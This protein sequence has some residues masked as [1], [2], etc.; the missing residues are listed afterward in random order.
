MNPDYRPEPTE[1][2]VTV[3]TATRRLARWLREADDRRQVAEGRSAWRSLDA[4]AWDSWLDRTWRRL[5]DWGS[6]RA[7]GSFLSDE[8]ERLLWEQ[9]VVELPTVGSILMPGQVAREAQAAWTL[10]NEFGVDRDELALAGSSAT[11][12]LLQAAAFVE[13][14]CL[15]EGWSRRTVRAR[16]VAE[17]TE[18]S[19]ALGDELIFDSFEEPR[20]LQ[21]SIMETIAGAGPRVR[22]ELR[23]QDGG[24]AVARQCADP[25][26]ELESLALAARSWLERDPHA[27]IGIVVLDLENRR[28]DVE[29]VFD[30]VLMPARVLPGHV[31]EAR[32]WNQ[33]LGKPLADWPVVAAALRLL[34]LS[35]E[36]APLPEM[37]QLLRSPFIGGDESELADRSRL[38]A[39]LR[40]RGVYELSIAGLVDLVREESDARRPECPDLEQRLAGIGGLLP[41]RRRRSAP[42]TWAER[43]GI[44][45]T[46]LG[47]PGPR[48]LDS[49]EYQ[50]VAKWQELLVRLAGLG[51]V[52]GDL[53][54][55]ECLDRL[56][57]LAQDT[58]F[59]PETPDA[60]IQVLGLHETAGLTFDA[61]WVAGT[62]HQAWPRSLRPNALIPAGIQ[63]ELGMP[64]SCAEAELAY[65]REKTSRLV[66]SADFVC[67]TWP[68]KI[69]DE[70]MRPS[71]LIAGLPRIEQP[72]RTRR[73]DAIIQ[74]SG[75]HVW[76]DDYRLPPIPK[77]GLIRGGSGA[78][79]SQ[80]A[81]PFRG[82]AAHRL[83]GQSLEM[84]APGVPPML[85]GKI[86][87][88]ALQWLWEGWGDLD[89]LKE[90]AAGGLQASVDATVGRACRLL[91]P[92]TGPLSRSVRVLEQEK[93]TSRVLALLEGDLLREDFEVA[94]L[95]DKRSVE[96]ADAR[97]NY[98]VDRVDRLAD[99]GL[100]LVDYKTGDSRVAAW[101]GERPKEPQLPLYAAVFA[102]EVAGVAFGCLKVGEEGYVGYADRSIAGTSIDDVA[103]LRHPPDDAA[104]WEELRALWRDRVTALARSHAD[105]DARVAPRRQSEDCRYCDLSTLCRRHELR[106][107]GMMPDE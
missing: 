103:G 76:T 68:G 57:R 31:T 98:R 55:A 97:L 46:A 87:H 24:I 95:E 15:D 49:I 37:S 69:D 81:C 50:C 79:R 39:W 92:D 21:R 30:D 65:A 5:R 3:V 35:I 20:P 89:G 71:P 48:G 32:P 62:H 59:Q 106:E 16:Q 63:R 78:L 90:E 58:V 12:Y 61:V 102:D 2:D 19:T 94:M 4:I 18:L 1:D 45:L 25:M 29:A 41:P 67:F 38:D 9:A 91:L 26:H 107:R 88:L 72:D 56:R 27:R 43:F 93:I 54:A 101:R 82:Q 74:Q 86:A 13:R 6:A 84:P 14:R 47:W 53:T 105:G 7:T 96:L 66:N 42:G 40:D 44:L 60:R 70:P 99:G 23:H 75:R 10:V 83:K 80:S 17:A 100:L 28:D 8:Q 52:S 73:Y 51:A 22:H 34:S 104:N 36:P 77:G 64:R 11:R 85:S 33:S